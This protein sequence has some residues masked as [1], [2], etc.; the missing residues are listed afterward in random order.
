MDAL[1]IRLSE[2]GKRR[3]IVRGRAGKCDAR[4]SDDKEADYHLESARMILE[5]LEGSNRRRNRYVDEHQ[6]TD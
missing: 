2:L 4:I 5:I 1:E 6:C 3:E